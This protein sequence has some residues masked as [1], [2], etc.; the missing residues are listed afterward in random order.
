MAA[1]PAVAESF[2]NV[3]NAEASSIINFRNSDLSES[4]CAVRTLKKKVV[5]RSGQTMNIS[6]RANTG[7]IRRNSPALFE[8]DEQTNMPID[9][10]V[11]EALTTVKQAKSSLI[12]IPVTN[13]TLQHDIVLPGR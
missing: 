13:T 4:L 7:P 2:D 12:D 1:L 8:P 5:I 6:C 11:Q 10:T 3:S 9:L